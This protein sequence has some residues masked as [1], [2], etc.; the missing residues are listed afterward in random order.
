MM[1][2]T[3]LDGKQNRV[4]RLLMLVAAYFLT[5]LLPAAAAILI[6]PTNVFIDSK[7]KAAA[8]WLENRGNTLQTYQMRVYSWSHTGGKEE[9]TEQNDIVGSPPIMQSNPAN[10]NWSG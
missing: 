4:A 2:L 8:M 7:E 6:W 5:G 1:R 3:D 10:G 9:L